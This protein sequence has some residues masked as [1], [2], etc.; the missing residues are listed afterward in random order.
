MGKIEKC[1]T[2][3]GFILPHLKFSRQI[4]R[5]KPKW[6]LRIVSFERGLGVK[7]V[8]FWRGVGVFLRSTSPFR[9]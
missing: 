8:P 2:L 6:S 7:K 4:I 3:K 1:E 5:P 9:D